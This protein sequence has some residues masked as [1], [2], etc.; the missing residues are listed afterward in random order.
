MELRTPFGTLVTPNITQDEET[1]I[2]SWTFEDFAA[3]IH[4][5]L[6]EDGEPIYPAMPYIYYTKMTDGDVESLWAYMQT[7]E[8]VSKEVE[9]NQLPFP[10]NVR[11]SLWAWRELYLEEGRFEPDASKDE[12]WNRGA[13]LVEAMTHCGACHTP[14]DALGG[15]VADRSLEGAKIEEWYAPDISDGPDSVI[16]GWSVE[17]LEAFLAGESQQDHV[18]VGSMHRVVEELSQSRPE[19][20]HAIAVYIKDQPGSDSEAAEA[21]PAVREVSDETRTAWA[22][23][24]GDNCETCHGADGQGAPGVAAS[25]VGSGAVIAEEPDNIISVVLE[26]IEA[27]GEYGIMPTFRDSM[28]DEQI[29][30]AVNYVRTS[31]GNEAAPNARPDMVEGMRNVTEATPEAVAAA[32]CPPVKIDRVSDDIRQ[33]IT[34]LVQQES[35]GPDVVEPIVSAYNADNPDA[36]ATERMT[37]L[38]GLYCRDVAETGAARN[39]VMARE[40]RFMNTLAALESTQ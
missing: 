14:R 32:T 28:T 34:D 10:F 21:K 19:D 30:A 22:T 6:N 40:L 23:V 25:L 13:Y 3:T 18:A 4:E 17:R 5:G 29:A 1:G 26:G 7:I 8:P 16:A 20:V 2:G 39:T 37:D 36:T 38:S 11:A 9:V 31:W 24:Y 33:S 27:R 15:P 35:V 12:V